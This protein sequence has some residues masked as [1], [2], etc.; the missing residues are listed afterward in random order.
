MARSLGEF[1]SKQHLVIDC[2]DSAIRAAFED[3]DAWGLS[4]AFDIHDCSPSL[5]R[6]KEA[7]ARFTAELCEHIGMKPYGECI[8]VHFGR[9]PRVAGISMLQLIETSNL[10]AHF[11][12]QTNRVYPDI[13]SCMYYNAFKAG[14]FIMRFFGG[15]SFSLTL[16]LR[17]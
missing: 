16:T 14:W 7:I 6:D 11:A 9:D 12:N 2:N 5:I 1:D 13:F 3:S 8:V 15:S 17:E 4:A 10:S